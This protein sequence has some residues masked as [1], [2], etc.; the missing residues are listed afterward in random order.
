MRYQFANLLLVALLVYGCGTGKPQLSAEDL[1]GTTTIILVRHAE[2]AD[3]GT[4][5]P[6]LT[7]LG[8][9]RAQRLAAMLAPTGVNAVYSTPYQRTRLTGLPLAELE[10][11]QVTE[12]DPRDQNFPQQ[13]LAEHVGETVLVVGHSNT[14]PMLVNALTGTTRYEQLDEMEYD[15]LF[16]VNVIG[17]A[18]RAMVFSY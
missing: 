13:L 3:D 11:L 8:Q 18:G 15:K 5:N 6:G 1:T 14:I 12:Y 9:A 17:G 7:P 10:T 4:S 16:V 2:K